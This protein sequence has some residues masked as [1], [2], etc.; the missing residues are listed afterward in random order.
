MRAFT[1][2]LLAVL[3]LSSASARATWVSAADTDGDATLRLVVQD[4]LKLSPPSTEC[5]FVEIEVFGIEVEFRAGDT[6]LLWVYEADLTNDD[7]I[8]ETVIDVTANEVDHGQCASQLSVG[9]P[10]I[11]LSVD[12]SAGSRPGSREA[13][14]T[15]HRVLARTPARAFSGGVR[16]FRVKA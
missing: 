10:P 11:V 13:L 4:T 12:S 1:L 14:P 3:C 5:C 15:A 8:F 7:L 9:R 6:I 16:P 2:F